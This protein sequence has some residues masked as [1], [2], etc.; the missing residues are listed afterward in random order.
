MYLCKKMIAINLVTAFSFLCIGGWEGAFA[1]IFVVN[2]NKRTCLDVSIHKPGA[3]VVNF[4]IKI[5][6]LLNIP[7]MSGVVMM[8][9]HIDISSNVYLYIYSYQYFIYV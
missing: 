3:A 1:E 7:N 5:I 6:I 9:W 4:T 8:E 2:G